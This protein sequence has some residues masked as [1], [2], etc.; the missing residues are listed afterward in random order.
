MIKKCYIYDV[1]NYIIKFVKYYYIYIMGK[2]L[3]HDEFLSKLPLDRN[4]EVIEQYTKG[5]N[6]IKTKNKYGICLVTPK[7]LIKGIFPN[8]QSAIDKNS[9][10]IN[11]SVEIH[12]NKFDYSL[13][14]YI[15]DEI[16]V[17]IICPVHGVFEQLP[18]SH[19]KHDCNKCSYTERK[20]NKLNNTH[21]RK[22]FLNESFFE[23]IDT[24]E[25]A[26]FLGFLYADGALYKDKSVSLD[27][28]KKDLEILYKFKDVLNYSKPL[29]KYNDKAAVV[30]NSHK[31]YNDLIKLGCTERKTFTLKYPTDNSIPKEL[32]HHFIR[33][34][35][36]GDGCVYR[37][38][39]RYADCISFLGTEHLLKGIESF[40]GIKNH[41][42][43]CGNIFRL[44]YHTQLRFKEVRNILYKDATIFLI[45]KY[46]KFYNYE[47]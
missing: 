4:Y 40:I 34:V 35:F 5:E 26:Y 19:Y 24:E 10:F 27:L 17:K 43:K 18:S 46:N 11:K 13:S 6:K 36:D 22:W 32:T 1:I 47:Q 29:K 16:K 2:K 21:Y 42:R 28:N 33:G 3:T 45:R 37:A 30:I 8:I 7:S 25:K 41:F 9:Y 14:K 23:I 20:F 38:K 44:S 39:K 12:G 31:M 15:N